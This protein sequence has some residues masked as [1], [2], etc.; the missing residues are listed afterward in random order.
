[1]IMDHLHSK[2]LPTLEMNTTKY[3]Y[4]TDFNQQFASAVYFILSYNK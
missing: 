4:A 1:M 3:A 2:R